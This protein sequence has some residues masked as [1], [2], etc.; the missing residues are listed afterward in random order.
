MGKLE[1]RHQI[2]VYLKCSVSENYVFLFLDKDIYNYLRD[3]QY[4]IQ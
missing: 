4:Y 1:N 2:P 3:I